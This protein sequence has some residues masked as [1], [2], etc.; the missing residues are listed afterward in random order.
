MVI[1]FIYCL[2]TGFSTNLN[3]GDIYTII[4]IMQG[5]IN[6][7]I[8]IMQVYVCNY[9]LFMS[10]YVI[11]KLFSGT[12]A[13]LPNPKL[14]ITKKKKMMKKKKRNIDNKTQIFPLKT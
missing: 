10:K 5:D 13:K 11:S 4:C 1:L 8:C 12:H 14:I 2:L 6:T 9:L 7:I 3:T